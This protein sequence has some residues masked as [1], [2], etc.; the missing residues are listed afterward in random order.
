MPSTSWS[1]VVVVAVAWLAAELAAIV[2][3]PI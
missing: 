2:Q 1:L 3:L